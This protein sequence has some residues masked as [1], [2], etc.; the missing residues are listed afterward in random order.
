MGLQSVLIR[1]C[2]SEAG[3]SGNL[4]HRCSVGPTL[5]QQGRQNHPRRRP[6]LLWGVLDQPDSVSPSPG[7]PHAVAVDLPPPVTNSPATTV[8][9]VGVVSLWFRLPIPQDEKQRRGTASVLNFPGVALSSAL[10]AAALRPR[11]AVPG[12]LRPI[13][14]DRSNAPGSSPGRCSPN[15]GQAIWKIARPT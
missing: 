5:R 9:D 11:R 8:I 13:K 10:G 3:N 4:A 1:A 15:K 12:T 14:T 6:D 2:S 7:R